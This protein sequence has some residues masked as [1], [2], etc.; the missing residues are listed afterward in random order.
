[1]AE[2]GRLEFEVMDVRGKRLTESATIELRHRTLNDV[3]KAKDVNVSTPVAIDG[4]HRTPQGDYELHVFAPSYHP[5]GRFVAVPASG[6]AHI[7]VKMAIRADRARGIF[8]PYEALDDRVRGVLERSSKVKAHEG[9]SGKAL[10]DK[11]TDPAKGGLLNI[12]VKSL[13]TKFSNGG[14][15]LP[16][17]T[18]NEIRGDRCFVSVP[19]SLVDQM[20][21]LVNDR[22]FHSVNGSLHQPPP[23]FAPAGSYKTLDQFGNLQLTFFKGGS[24][25]VADVDIDD[26]AGLGHVFQVL[27]NHV[28]GEPTHP[29]NIMQILLGAQDLDPGYTLVPKV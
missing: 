18:I 3:R 2:T 25:C 8:P 21:T 26:A 6:S 9:L 20:P 19:E 11:L 16:H 17:L 4:L 28:T 22:A 13:V 5:V 12:A 27:H 10:Y 15:L 24:G 23:G 14:D 29:Y 1:M 7:A